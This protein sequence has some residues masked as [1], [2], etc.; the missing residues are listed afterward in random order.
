M[1]S[2]GAR[3][4]PESFES[5]TGNVPFADS[6]RA[7]SPSRAEGSANAARTRRETRIKWTFSKSAVRVPPS[8]LTR[9]SSGGATAERE[10]GKVHVWFAAPED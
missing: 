7:S 6:R 2:A 4:S 1:A 9:R 3:R 8:T 10:T 5:P